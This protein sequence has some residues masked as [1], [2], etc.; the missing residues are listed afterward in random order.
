MLT[1]SAAAL[2]CIVNWQAARV[3]QEI[4]SF[5]AHLGVAKAQTAP[6]FQGCRVHAVQEKQSAKF[7][8]K[9]PSEHPPRLQKRMRALRFDFCNLTV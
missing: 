1:G 8:V 6:L 3:S 5:M 7:S 9:G 4:L 2:L